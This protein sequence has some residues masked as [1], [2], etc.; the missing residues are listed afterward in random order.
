[1]LEIRNLS[2]GY[3][4]NPVLKDISL[5]LAEGTGDQNQRSPGDEPAKPRDSFWRKLPGS[6]FEQENQP[7]SFSSRS[8]RLL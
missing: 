8:L 2:T 6:A 3:P 1:M 5:S 7:R 4:G